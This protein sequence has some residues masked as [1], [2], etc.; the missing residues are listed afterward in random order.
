MSYKFPKVNLA[1]EVTG[2]LPVANL[3]SGTSASATTFW[4]G[5]GTWGTPAGA[6]DVSSSANLTDNAVVRGDGGV[7]G[8][9]TS[10]MLISDAGEMTNP[11]QPSFLGVLSVQDDNATGDGT[12]FTLGSGNAITEIYDQNSDF[13]TSTFTAPVTGR[14]HIGMIVGLRGLTA[15]HTGGS[16]T[17]VTSNRSYSSVLSWGAVRDAS[18][19]CRI[20]TSTMAD[21]DVGDTLTYTVTVSGSTKVVDIGVTT[22]I[23][24]NLE[25]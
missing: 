25:C 2:N 24:A 14:Y 7:K 22:Y 9:Q 21:M 5:D 10:T 19:D 16:R 6:G 1:S 23:Y 3:N 13:A 18:N 12:A 20:D 17:L 8:V 4:R 15:S 11:S